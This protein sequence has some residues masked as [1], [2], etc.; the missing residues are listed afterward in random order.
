MTP[1]TNEH[2]Q[3]IGPA[4]QDWS[5][6]PFPDVRVMTGKHCRLEPLMLHQ[7]EELYVEL[8]GPDD[9]ALWTYLGHDKPADEATF[10]DLVEEWALATD[11]V[12]V[13][14]RTAEGRACGLFSFLRIDPANGVVE[15]G[16]ILFGRRLQRTTA[17]TEALH[18]AAK[19]VFD[20]GYRRYEWKCDALNAPS[21][22]AAERFGFVR[23]GLFRKAVVTKG[24]SRDTLWLSITD[25]EWPTRRAALEAWLAPG[26]HTPTGQRKRLEEFREER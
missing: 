1:R 6:A 13:V 9:D 10:S 5:P 17:A 3:P 21:V 25:E 24:R 2:G 16:S 18:L 19:H 11:R 26:N 7:T 14:V 12:T 20:L 15:I 23:E 4:L 22:R 8:C